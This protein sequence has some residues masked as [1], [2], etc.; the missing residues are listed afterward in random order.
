V[1][2]SHSSF[3]KFQLSVFDSINVQEHYSA[4]DTEFED[5]YKNTCSLIRTH[6]MI[7]QDDI[8]RELTIK[9]GSC[10]SNSR[11]LSGNSQLDFRFDLNSLLEDEK[12]RRS[13][14]VTS[15]IALD[16]I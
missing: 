11:G 14:I 5:I 10:K 8:N 9:F 16:Y 13:L 2:F 3:K 12:K 6:Y 7:G 15:Y 1:K 4:N